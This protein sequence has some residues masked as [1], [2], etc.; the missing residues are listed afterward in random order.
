MNGLLPEDFYSSY[1][2]LIHSDLSTLEAALDCLTGFLSFALGFSILPEDT[3]T[4][5]LR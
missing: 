1:P 4:H 5:R 3:L 2:V